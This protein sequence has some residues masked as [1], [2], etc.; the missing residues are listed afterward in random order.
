MTVFTTKLYTRYYYSNQ[1]E[2]QSGQ[3]KHFRTL[4][5]AQAYADTNERDFPRHDTRYRYE[6][7]EHSI[8]N[9]KFHSE[10]FCDELL[11]E[12]SEYIF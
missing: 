8:N 5:E 4:K 11:V 1:E 9:P 6:I 12:M 10:D 3:D 7:A 2:Y